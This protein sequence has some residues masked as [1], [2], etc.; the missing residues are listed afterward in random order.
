MTIEGLRFFGALRRKHAVTMGRKSTNILRNT[1]TF[2]WLICLSL[3]ATSA[4][5][6]SGA[7][8]NPCMGDC[9]E[10]GNGL[11]CIE[12]QSGGIE[13]TFDI[14][15]PAFQL[16]G[17]VQKDGAKVFNERKEKYFLKKG[18]EM[19]WG[20]GDHFST[21]LTLKEL[22]NGSAY[23]SIEEEHLPP[24]THKH[25]AYKKQRECVVR[26]AP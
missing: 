8:V 5:A 16:N 18:E 14:S 22:R 25:L 9:G 11:K 20:D 26:K 10:I 1:R 15:S 13:V 2:L 21:S 17:T 12:V 3:V 4:I 7:I 6:N 19:F 24:A 23:I